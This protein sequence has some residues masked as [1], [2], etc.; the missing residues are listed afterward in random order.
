MFRDPPKTP[1]PEIFYVWDFPV[2][3]KGK[4]APYIKNLG[5]QGLP[6]GAGGGLRGRFLLKFFMFMNLLGP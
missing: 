4:E 2:F 1:P 5:C 3:L 6:R